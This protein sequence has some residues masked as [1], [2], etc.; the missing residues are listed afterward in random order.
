MVGFTDGRC[1]ATLN[2][3]DA[4]MEAQGVRTEGLPDRKWTGGV[5]E[6]SMARDFIRRKVE[7]AVRRPESS[8]TTRTRPMRRRDAVKQGGR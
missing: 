5:C 2:R 3:F 8:G 6:L 7:P 1:H 4:A